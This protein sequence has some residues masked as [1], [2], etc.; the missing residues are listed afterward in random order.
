MF[1]TPEEVQRLLAPQ[2]GV[3]ARLDVAGRVT[4]QYTH[5]DFTES[6]AALA[7]QIFRLMVRDT[8]VRVRVAIAD[9]LKS[10]NLPRDIVMV[11]AQDEEDKVA[12]PVLKHSD[13]LTESDLLA[14]VRSTDKVTRQVAV[15]ERKD[16]TPEL[17]KELLSRGKP[18][19]A[20]A[21]AKNESAQLDER[22]LSA[23]AER[24]SQDS[25]TMQVL[26]DRPGLP[27]P[28]A[29][30][31][32][33]LVSG[34]V[35]ENLRKKYRL[36]ESEL[37]MA[38]EKAR[39]VAALELLRRSNSN[40]ETERLA[41]QFA[42]VGHLTPS[43]MFGALC[44]GYNW[45]F[46]ASLARLSGISIQNVQKLLED[47]GDLGFRAVYN[48]SGLP[49]SMLEAVKLLL[50]IVHDL[51]RD[52]NI[53][54]GEAFAHRVGE[55]LLQTSDGPPVENLGYLISLLNLRKR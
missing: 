14:L 33:S 49:L 32:V 40:M 6:E 19:I 24:F 3:D 18:E 35:A 41:D 29:A 28:V 1:L 7:E 39:D 54:Q 23:I 47:H 42:M 34:S 51:R 12:V 17:A 55:R 44:H 15:S 43:L 50:S 13:I 46:E 31:V 16:V 45:F 22:L 21:L 9:Q 4:A 52:P 38:A 2:E 25:T 37:Q 11:M 48:K 27:M 8:E 53:T 36:S 10:S 26:A 20:Q 5:G 30:K